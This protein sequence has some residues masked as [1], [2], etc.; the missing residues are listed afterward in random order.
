[1]KNHG[2]CSPLS[3]DSENTPGKIVTIVNLGEGSAAHFTHALL[4]HF[5]KWRGKP[6]WGN[7]KNN[8]LTKVPLAQCNIQP[9]S[10]WD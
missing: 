9:V 6:V 7:V 8:Q 10:L 2:I 3:S 1:M 5:P 4:S